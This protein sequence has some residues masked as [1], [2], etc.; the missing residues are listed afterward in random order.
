MIKFFSFFILLGFMAGGQERD[1]G[2]GEGWGKKAEAFA[3]SHIRMVWI[4]EGDLVLLDSAD[5]KNEVVRPVG[6]KGARPIITPSGRQVVFICFEEWASYVVN[7][8]GAGLTKL[9]DGRVTHVRRDEAGA[10][11][12]YW[13]TPENAIRTARL[14]RIGESQEIW[15][16]SFPS[17][18]GKV[19]NWQTSA[20]GRRVA[21]TVP[22][23]LNG[24]AALPR[25]GQEEFLALGSGCWPQIA[26][27]NSYMVMHLHGGKHSRLAMYDAT[28]QKAW[29]VEV[30]PNPDPK[31]TGMETPRWLNDPRLFIC[32]DQSFH[33]AQPRIYLGRF[34][35]GFSAIEGWLAVSPPGPVGEPDGWLERAAGYPQPARTPSELPPLAGKGSS[36]WPGQHRGLEFLWER[37]GAANEIRDSSGKPFRRCRAS[38]RG[39]ARPYLEGQIDLIGGRLEAEGL[40]K[41]F[42]TPFKTS[43]QFTLQLLL[44]PFRRATSGTVVWFGPPNGPAWMTFEQEEA[45]FGLA[46]AS[47]TPGSPHARVLLGK[48]SFNLDRD[49]RAVP[50]LAHLA[51]VFKEETCLFY[52]NGQKVGEGKVAGVDLGS[53]GEG[54]LLFGSEPD[55]S[56]N[57]RGRIE[58]VAFFSRALDEQELAADSGRLAL[59]LTRRN[60]IYRWKVEGKLVEQSVIGGKKELGEY[61]RALAVNA[62][63][64]VKRNAL[65][66]EET[67]RIKVS[68]WAYLDHRPVLEPRTLGQSYPLLLEPRSK[69]RLEGER[70]FI[71][72]ENLEGKEFLDI[73]RPE[74]SRPSGRDGKKK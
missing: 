70:V 7:W 36:L 55:G 17:R 21:A 32:T 11:W 22:W 45:A 73:W 16:F 10:E 40:A 42:G 35:P 46:L 39:G 48:G 26:R 12:A 3:Q 65:G 2:L 24:V 31:R 38:L 27:D 29:F 66:A 61:P 34:N 5:G 74:D 14:D 60:A 25:R 62:Y 8:D 51:L 52:F 9:V 20:D 68:H 71:H 72:L 43:R 49:P 59:E 1:S 50:D 53:W 58:S 64:I 6:R 18:E 33:Q 57:W 67:E 56:K 37:L 41:D 15:K 47:T 28:C 13:Q 44:A 54:R 23:P 19:E 30:Q 63:E 69:H 4:R